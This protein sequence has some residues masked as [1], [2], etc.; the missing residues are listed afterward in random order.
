MEQFVK[1][2]P[3]QRVIALASAAPFLLAGFCPASFTKDL[4]MISESGEISTIKIGEYRERIKYELTR[5]CLQHKA[6][7]HSIVHFVA[8]GKGN[9]LELTLRET[10]LSPAQN[11]ALETEL[12]AIKFANAP[13]KSG[14]YLKL[15]VNF[16]IDGPPAEPPSPE[17]ETHNAPL[18]RTYI[19]QIQTL[20]DE[21]HKPEPEKKPFYDASEWSSRGGEVRRWNRVALPEQLKDSVAEISRALNRG[22][23][24][25]VKANI[26]YIVS[27]GLTLGQPERQTLTEL[28]IDTARHLSWRSPDLSAQVE[29][30]CQSVQ[31]LIDSFSPP[32]TQLKSE[33]LFVRSRFAYRKGNFNGAKSFAQEIIQLNE[34]DTKAT[35]IRVDAYRELARAASTQHD[36]DKVIEYHTNAMNLLSKT[37]QPE[38]A[39]KITDLCGIIKIKLELNQQAEA[40]K[41]A[42]EIEDTINKIPR[43][44]GQYIPYCEPMNEL[45]R[46]TDDFGQFPLPCHYLQPKAVPVAEILCKS[47]Y[48]LKTKMYGFR[49]RDLM[50]LCLFLLAHKKVAESDALYKQA[51]DDLKNGNPQYFKSSISSLAKDYAEA[52]SLAGVTETNEHLTQQ[53]DE[54]RQDREKRAADERQKTEETVK[55]LGITASSKDSIN[56]RLKMF[57]YLWRDGKFPEAR[58]M[59]EKV[60]M[61][62]S[63]QSDLDDLRESFR[64]PVD[65]IIE[66]GKSP[67]DT[68]LA[69]KLCELF[70]ELGLKE[71]VNDNKQFKIDWK[72]DRYGFPL[73]LLSRLKDRSERDNGSQAERM[74]PVLIR[75][76]EIRQAKHYPNEALVSVRQALA[77]MNQ[78][79]KKND[80]AI[81]AQSELIKVRQLQFDSAK[82]KFEDTKQKR[83]NKS[84]GLDSKIEIEKNR[85]SNGTRNNEWTLQCY[86]ARRKALAET[87][88]SSLN[89]YD[90]AKTQIVSDMLQLATINVKAGKFEAARQAEEKATAIA[91]QEGSVFQDRGAF[92]HQLRNLINEYAKLPGKVDDEERVMQLAIERAAEPGQSGELT[93]LWEPVQSIVRKLELKHEYVRACVLIQNFVNAAT[94]DTGLSGRNIDWSFNLAEM[95]LDYST[96]SEKAKGINKTEYQRKSKE[97]FDKVFQTVL[98]NGDNERVK[99][100]LQQRVIALRNHNLPDEAKL[101]EDS[102]YMKQKDAL[103]KKH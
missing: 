69:I 70:E 103:D 14:G 68:K 72:D 87:L 79:L 5:G 41:L 86:K 62:M 44:Y 54:E 38:C 35:K 9:L 88:D 98:K 39:Q 40:M 31:K 3:F 15:T 82:Q 59:M 11:A 64:W 43:L 71:F 1:T 97:I 77:Q 89:Q 48:K 32:S 45:E 17:D 61:A 4:L 18:D 47:I 53:L 74:L 63:A 102:M 96:L 90:R 24:D 29:Y 7:L 73:G 55:Q 51:I 28:L 85:Y 60:I 12:K 94:K 49:E 56:A 46:I 66:Q 34:K 33:L 67:E 8:D 81:A 99:L 57:S 37:E 84:P 83:E 75:M 92:I 50:N 76:V 80:D 91:K 65:Q 36:R 20:L 95:Y 26:N 25:S 42:R 100:Y 58:E 6:A 30:I 93:W 21:Q 52:R 23:L 19:N 10:K 2:R 101:L 13:G 16:D 78:K 22:E 27:Q